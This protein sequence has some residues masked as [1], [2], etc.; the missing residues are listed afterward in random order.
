MQVKN[1]GGW[2]AGGAWEDL[3]NWPMLRQLDKMAFV[4]DDSWDEV[5]TWMFEAFAGLTGMNARFFREEWLEDA[6]K[7]VLEAP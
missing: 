7:W 4:S 3:N 5:L 6:W 2:T 1:F